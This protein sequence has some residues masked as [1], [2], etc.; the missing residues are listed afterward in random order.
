[1]I[2][3]PVT[4][5]S[6][7]SILRIARACIVRANDN[8]VGQG[9]VVPTG[10]PIATDRSAGFGWKPSLTGFAPEKVWSGRGPLQ[11]AVKRGLRGGEGR[12][13]GAGR[14]ARDAHEPQEGTDVDR[15]KQV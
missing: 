9:S 1:M 14:V 10:K 2:D 8:A 5:H 4:W 6:V 3:E 12:R 7:A 15:F 11:K 13:Y